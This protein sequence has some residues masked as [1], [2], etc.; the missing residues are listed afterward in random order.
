LINEQYKIDNLI[1]QLKIFFDSD[2][3]IA[4][5][6][7]QEGASYLLLQLCEL[8]IINGITSSQVIEECRKNIQQKL[9]EAISLFAQIVKETLQVLPNPCKEELKKYQGM[10]HPKDLPILVAAI[11]NDAKFLITFNVKHYYPTSVFK[12]QI[13]KP[14]ELLQKIKLVLN[15]L[16]EKSTN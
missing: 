16:S 8:K 11:T 6:A 13:I 7:S 14:G 12:I 4:G 5:S 2:A 15:Q 3:L 10:A 1:M 9:P